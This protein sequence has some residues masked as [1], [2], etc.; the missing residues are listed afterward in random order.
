MT[1]KEAAKIARKQIAEGKT[2]QETFDTLM[3]ANKLPSVE[4]ATIIQ[5][6][7]SLQTREK[8]K[9]ANVILMTLI[10]LTIVFK[11][12][13]GIFL[14]MQNGLLTLPLLLI[15]PL[16][17]IYLLWGVLNFR[18]GAHRLV[19]IF[20][21]LGIVRSLQQVIGQAFDPI[22]LL[23]FAIAA[24]LIGLGFYL[25]NKLHPVYKTVRESYQNSEGYEL[26]RYVI[27][28]EE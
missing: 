17:N 20:T 26:D 10:I 19:A 6:I 3:A 23:D 11:L 2:R 8:Y 5:G 13:A 27:K 1:L 24:G 16:L 7:P 4:F 28:F 12:I 18:P 25:N 15:L 9:T 14:V 22:L 21:I